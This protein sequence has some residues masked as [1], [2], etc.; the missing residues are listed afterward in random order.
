MILKDFSTKHLMFLVLGTCI[1]SVTSYS[2]IF[3]KKGYINTWLF[4]VISALLF[5]LFLIYF[6]KIYAK[7]NISDSEHIFSNVYMYIFSIG[8]ILVSIESAS[9]FSSS[10]HTNYFLRTPLWYCLL[11]IIVP[12]GYVLTKNISSVLITTMITA[13]I[14]F[15]LYS[16]FLILCMFKA[17]F[18]SLLPIL[19]G[20]LQKNSILCILSLIGSLS[21]VMIISPYAPYFDCKHN[22]IKNITL[23]FLFCSILMVLSFISVTTILGENLTS[24]IFYPEYVLSQNIQIS[25]FIEY[26]QLVFIF[27][28][29]SMFFIK[30]ILSSYA[31]ILLFKNKITNKSR[32]ILIYSI[33][34]FIFSYLLSKNQYILFNSLEI[35]QYIWIVTF[36]VAP[37]LSLKM[38]KI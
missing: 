3:I 23:A 27:K 36:I 31:I 33:V 26:G 19:S 30:Y 11:F 37:F 29:V 12:A 14:S 4:S 21:S 8:L 35:M 28:S 20:G 17:D 6:L 2:S 25:N 38:S 24:N 9:C 18:S 16:V 1:I 7:K 32:F 13:G 22:L 34:I 15:A 5:T 10:I